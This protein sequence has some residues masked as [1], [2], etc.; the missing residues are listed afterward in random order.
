MLPMTSG[1][2]LVFSYSV[3]PLYMSTEP[4]AGFDK[5]GNVSGAA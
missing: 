4:P 2:P 3:Y 5:G 1:A